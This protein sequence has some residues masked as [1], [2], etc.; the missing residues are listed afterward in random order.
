M[1]DASTLDGD[2]FQGGVGRGGKGY[3]AIIYNTTSDRL[4]VFLKGDGTGGAW[5]GIA[6]V[7]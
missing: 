6:T 1:T 2:E 5:C 3:G 4:E 7:A